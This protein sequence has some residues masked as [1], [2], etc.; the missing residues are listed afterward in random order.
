MLEILLKYLFAYTCFFNV[1]FLEREKETEREWGR[2][3]KRGRHRI[4]TRLQALNCKHRAWCGA[5][6]HEP[7]DDDLSRSQTPIRLSHPGAPYAC[8]IFFNFTQRPHL[9]PT[10]ISNSTFCVPVICPR[11]PHSLHMY[12]IPHT[13]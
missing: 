11:C 4:Q 10:Y 1:Y 13:V 12:C 5:Q 6:T 9:T 7:L 3:R 2:G 8:F